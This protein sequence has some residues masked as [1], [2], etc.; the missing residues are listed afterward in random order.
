MLIKRIIL[1]FLVL[2]LVCTGCSVTKR[3]IAI[4]KRPPLY[5]QTVLDTT[6]HPVSGLE[7]AK[8]LLKQGIGFLKNQDTDKAEWNF[9]E[10]I[11][12]DP[13]Y[14]PAYYWLARAR[15]RLNQTQSSFE[16]LN[17]AEKL[18]Q[19]SPDWL[20]RVDQFRRFLLDKT[21]APLQ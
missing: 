4:T 3:K 2:T 12:I 5:E 8:E 15:Y 7:P 20:E 9:E 1:L 19:S 17:K 6:A 11:K 18:L 10:A 16:L 13:K 14:G 21:A